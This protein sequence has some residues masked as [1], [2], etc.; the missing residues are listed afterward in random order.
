MVS[1]APLLRGKLILNGF[2]ATKHEKHR[3]NSTFLILRVHKDLKKNLVNRELSGMTVQSRI[4]SLARLSPRRAP[5]RAAYSCV[6][7]LY[8]LNRLAHKTLL[9]PLIPLFINI[10]VNIKNTQVAYAQLRNCLDRPTSHRNTIKPFRITEPLVL[11][12]PLPCLPS[13]TPTMTPRLTAP[14]HSMILPSTAYQPIWKTSSKAFFQG[15]TTVIVAIIELVIGISITPTIVACFVLLVH[16]VVTKVWHFFTNSKRAWGIE[17][18]Q[19]RQS[20]M[21]L[22]I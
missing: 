7:R 20:H 2:E 3:N 10:I 8:L 1:H 21:K 17:G 19:A 11:N 15:V 6:L 13:P 4:E 14:N 22:R 16:L 5:Y 12:T 9:P 18:R